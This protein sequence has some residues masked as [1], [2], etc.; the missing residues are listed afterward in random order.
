MTTNSAPLNPPPFPWYTR[1]WSGVARAAVLRRLHSIRGGEI[2]LVD[3]GGEHRYGDSGDELATTIRIQSPEAFARIAFGG[4][5]GVAE[6]YARGLWVVDDLPTLCRIFARSFLS[7]DDSWTPK[8]AEPLARV[9]HF[10]RANSRRGAARN[11]RDHYDLGNDFFSLFLD[12][13]MTYSCGVYA[14]AGASLRDASVEKLDRICRKLDVK[15]G[16]RIV[17][18]GCGWGSFALHAARNYGA[19]VTGVTISKEQQD[20]AEARVREA[21]L[22]E[23]IQIVRRD[24]RDLEGQFD[25]VVSIEMIEAV[26]DENLE[27]YFATIDRLLTPRGRALVQAITMPDRDHAAYLRSVDFIQKYIFPGSCLPCMRR[28]QESVNGATMLRIVDAEDIALHYALTLG[29]WRE[30]FL[31][32]KDDILRL[33]YSENFVRLWDYYFSYCLGGF[34]ERYLGDLQVLMVKAD[35]TWDASLQPEPAP[36]P[37]LA[38]L[39]PRGAATEGAA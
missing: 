26:G 19:H 20:F 25:H 34:A 13:T 37:S 32:K 14:N 10:F 12:D 30:R 39:S 17:E 7:G 21:G 9:A 11:I 5:L 28:I 8:F 6:S 15:P 27:T 4:T 3:S 16:D 35:V 1:V 29:E 22:G 31:A 18:I 38:P 36:T 23:Q 2:R 33:G 24:Y